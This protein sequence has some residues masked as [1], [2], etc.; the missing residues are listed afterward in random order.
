MSKMWWQCIIRLKDYMKNSVKPG[1]YLSGAI[2]HAIGNPNKW[3]QKMHKELYKD[4]K[5]VIPYAKDCPF[6][7][8][9]ELYKSFIKEQF[10]M[11]DMSDVAK[12]Q[13]FFV[14]IDKGVFKGAGTVSEM[15]LAAWLGKHIIY[16]YENIKEIDMPGWS[17]GC[18]E[19]GIRVA[20]IDE[21]IQIYKDL[22]NINSKKHDRNKGTKA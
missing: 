5:V 11:P 2:E 16:M 9:E 6:K 7:K 1:L 21:A 10:I 17:L 8:D 4:Y 19:G 15:A 12:S 13:Y 22:A 20:S 14:K 3:R 18:L